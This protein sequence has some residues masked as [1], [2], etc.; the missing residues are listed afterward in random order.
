M[1]HTDCGYD[2]AL[3]AWFLH[4]IYRIKATSS[5]LPDLRSE[6]VI[7]LPDTA[8]KK[9]ENG[10]L[11]SLCKGV[12]S[13]LI[14]KNTKAPAL[15]MNIHPNINMLT[16]KIKFANLIHGKSPESYMTFLRER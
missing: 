13:K 10:H 14:S 12:M 4:P 5:F 9:V 7:F 15:P 2:A 1:L 6:I 16:L 11:R 8:G 3:A